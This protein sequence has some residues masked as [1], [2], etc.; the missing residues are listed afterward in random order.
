M[1]KNVW[2]KKGVRFLSVGI[3][4]TLID[5]TILNCLVLIAHFPTIIANL[6]SASISITTSYFLNHHIVFRSQ[7]QHS[8]IRFVRFFA[9]TGFGI[10]AI[11][12]LA[13]FF[14]Q[15]ILRHYN[16]SIQSL[17]NDAHVASISVRAA[18][19]NI[20]KLLAVAVAMGWNFTVYHLIIFKTVHSEEALEVIPPA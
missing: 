10:L 14:I 17:L 4:N 13:I 19:L 6:I 15:K 7:E 20:A 16:G 2:A 9:V 11:Q 1:L 18:E 12:T 3:V 5:L 8:L